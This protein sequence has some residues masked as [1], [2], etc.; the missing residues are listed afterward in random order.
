MGTTTQNPA[1]GKAI[2]R[3]LDKMNTYLDEVEAA[4]NHS[5]LR[6]ARVSQADVAWQLDHLLKVCLSVGKTLKNSDPATF[7]PSSSMKRRIVF[8][9]GKIPRGKAKAPSYV[10]PPEL[11]SEEDL[12]SQLLQARAL[13]DE[14][15]QLAEGKYIDHP[16]FG[17]LHR[18]D[19]VKFLCIH[20]NHHLKIVRDIVKIAGK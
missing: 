16:I 15:A 7:K 8:T 14:V 1:S 4:I 6:D 9:T 20:T 12:R 5:T 13:M 10:R 11:V 19:A 17:H 2:L 18:N 3:R